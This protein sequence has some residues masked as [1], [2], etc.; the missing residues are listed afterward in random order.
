M[1]QLNTSEQLAENTATGTGTGAGT[2]SAPITVKVPTKGSYVLLFGLGAL[3]ILA[4]AW[5]RGAL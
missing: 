2:S 5:D 1:Q 4:Y 3:L